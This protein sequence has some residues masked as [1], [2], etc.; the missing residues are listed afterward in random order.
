MASDA[1][2][3]AP[4]VLA[5]RLAL[6]RCV[7]R[8]SVFQAVGGGPRDDCARRMVGRRTSEP[9]IAAGPVVGAMAGTMGKAAAEAVVAPRENMQAA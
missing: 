2:R 7:L 6:K 4:G 3:G 1:L 5:A 8:K 9:A